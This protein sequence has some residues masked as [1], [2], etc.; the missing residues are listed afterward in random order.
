M[1]R[2]NAVGFYIRLIW[3]WEGAQNACWSSVEYHRLSRSQGRCLEFLNLRPTHD[4]GSALL[5]QADRPKH[6]IISQLRKRCLCDSSPDLKASITLK[7]VPVHAHK[8]HSS[9]ECPKDLGEY[10]VRNLSPRKALPDSEAYRDGWIEV[11]TG[12]RGT[13]DDRKG[14]T[15]SKAPA[16]LKDAAEGRWIGLRGI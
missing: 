11:A 8:Q 13:G 4:L 9:H 10:V 5:L 7:Y 14:D 15:N 1:N 12:C 6:R 16:N 2:V 3:V